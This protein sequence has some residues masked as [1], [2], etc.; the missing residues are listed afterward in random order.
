MTIDMKNAEYY[1]S[2]PYTVILRRDEEGDVVARVDELAGCAAHGKTEQEA[3]QNLREAQELWI[4]DCLEQ[5]ESVPEPVNEEALPSGKWVQR[6]PRSL[7]KKLVELAKR[8][9]V[10]LNQL[11]TSILSEAVGIRKAPQEEPTLIKYV[12]AV[13]RLHTHLKA[14]PEVATVVGDWDIK[15]THSRPFPAR[16]VV[17]I[18]GQGLPNQIE[19]K[20][21]TYGEKQTKHH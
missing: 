1:L 16:N 12:A 7:H 11:T 15:Q 2:L 13:S 17:K 18:L 6:V 4:T 8:D 3:L 5:G 21:T 10:S 14:V 9:K 19:I 20:D